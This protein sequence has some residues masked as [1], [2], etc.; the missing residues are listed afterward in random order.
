MIASPE[1]PL[2]DPADFRL[3]AGLAHVCAAGETPFLWRHDEA[4]ARY[5]HDKSQGARGR[6]SQETVVE[7]TRG[8]LAALWGVRADEIGW[9]SNVAEGMSL[10]LDSLGLGQGDRVCV[11]DTEYPSV[12]APLLARPGAAH[13]LRLAPATGTEALAASIDDRTRVVLVSYVSYLNGE[14]FD[15]RALRRAADAVGALLIV[16]FT[17]AS[18]Y[19]PIPA[20][21]ADFAFSASYKWMLGMTGTAAAYWN[22]LRQP[23]WAPVSA[24]WYSLATDGTRYDQGIRLRDDA[25][26]FTRGN[27]AHASLYVLS[28][29]LDYLLGFEPARIQAHVQGLT[30]DLLGRL[31]SHGLESST[32]ADPARHGAS[33]CIAR[34]DAALL[35]R[36]LDE[37]GVLAW[38]GRGRLRISFH[39]YNCRADVDRIES[40][41][42][43]ALRT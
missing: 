33:V 7:E 43:D 36:R 42:L 27:P 25:L 8:K 20:S 35:H 24:G 3:P 4:L 40:A 39:G 22:R 12:V 15:L 21:I 10:V 29:A 19:L 14:R 41:L 18:G 5:I 34:P 2:F 38:N 17:Q 6:P 9:V 32:P 16:D 11:M 31:A 13:E 1:T 26:R 37:A 30:T 23:D 28:S